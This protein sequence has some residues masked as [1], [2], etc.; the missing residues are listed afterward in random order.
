M[1]VR[2]NETMRKYFIFS[3]MVILLSCKNE[4]V[5]KPVPEIVINTPEKNQHF[6]NGDEIHI[7]GNVTNTVALKEVAVNMTDGSNNNEFF[8]NHFS[9][10][11][12]LVYLL[13]TKYKIES[14]KSTSYKVLVQAVDKNGTSVTKELTII[15]N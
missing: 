6:A 7:T 1:T 9:A 10:D 13:D 8:H 15:I 14:G 3:V 5:V 11:N 2:K 12:N 4:P